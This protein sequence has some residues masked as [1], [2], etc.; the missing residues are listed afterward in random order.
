[1]SRT[2]NVIVHVTGMIKSLESQIIF[3]YISC[4]VFVLGECTFGNS[5]RPV[6][7]CISSNHISCKHRSSVCRFCGTQ[8]CRILCRWKVRQMHAEDCYHCHHHHHNHHHQHHHY[9]HHHHH[10]SSLLSLSSSS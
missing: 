8:I 9:H 7:I 10:H 5:C 6:S 1:M 3:I 2:L 4:R